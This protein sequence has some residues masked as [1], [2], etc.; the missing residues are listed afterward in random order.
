MSL[1]G[2]RRFRGGGYPNSSPLTLTVYACV[3]FSGDDAIA[4]EV[5]SRP[6]KS[7][8][9][10]KRCGN[11]NDRLPPE[12]PKPFC[13]KCIQKLTGKETSQIMKEFLTVQTEMLSTLKSFQATLKPR[14]SEAHSSKDAS[15]QESSTSS[16]RYRAE[17]LKYPLPHDSEEECDLEVPNQEFSDEGVVDS[18]EE[19]GREESRS[20]RHIFSADDME[21]LLK[22]IYASE[23][24]QEPAAQVSAQD[25]MYRG[26]IK[27]QARVLPV[28]SALK[29]VILREW[30]E[31]ERRLLKYKTWKRR[32]P[33]S[34]ENEE[35]FFKTPRLDASLAQ[36]SKQSDLSFEDTGNLKDQMDRRAETILRRAWEANAAAM[37]PALASACIARNADTWVCK[38][39]DHVSRTS[40]SKEVLDSLEVIGNA[41]AYLADAAVETVRTTAKTGALLNSA[42]RALWVKTWDGDSSSKTHLCGLPFEG[43][44]LFGAG[45]DQA[46]ARSTEKGKKISYQ[47]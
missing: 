28:H 33:F 14:D 43:T 38:L 10:S 24:I 22:A 46:L 23:E 26:L 37:S 31:P 21:D 9:R 15:S 35:K 16:R 45:L 13:F 5:A 4:R 1:T 12:H 7:S 39:M 25:R 18:Q 27:P 32:C 19:D 17:V 41:V 44:L 8:T 11:C 3:F 40:K 34:E 29:E 42:R 36:V 30:K 20:S 6:V 47:T 2:L